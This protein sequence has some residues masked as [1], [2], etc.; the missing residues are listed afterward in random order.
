MVET[1]H[2]SPLAI[3]GATTPHSPELYII[4]EKK[5]FILSVF[6]FGLYFYYWSYKNWD[7]YKK[8]TQSDIWPWMRGLF[9]IFFIHA[10]YRRANQKIRDS[11]RSFDFDFEQ[12]ATTFVVLTVGLNML[13]VLANRMDI[14]PDFRVWIFL[15]IPLRTYMV[16]KCQALVNFAAD[17]PGGSTNSRFTFSSYLLIAIGTVIWGLT[18]YG[19][20]L[21][22]NP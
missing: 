16:Q 3:R 4:S 2:S 20:W 8:A 6:T 15:V 11:G 12:W 14:L 22:Y 21:Y 19:V 18:F 9:Y 7:V 17:D 1:I 13:S 5:L 10:L